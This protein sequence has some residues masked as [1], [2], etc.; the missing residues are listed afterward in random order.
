MTDGYAVDGLT[1]EGQLLSDLMLEVFRLNGRLLAAGDTLVAPVGL[2]SA[3]WQILGAVAMAP[4]PRP[5]AHLARRMGVS[6]QAVQRLVNEMAAAGLVVLQPNPDHRRAKLVTLT[7]AG[8]DALA[9]AIGRHRPWANRLSQ[10]LDAP[11]LS[12]ALA[13]LRNLSQRLDTT[14]RRDLP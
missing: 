10:G 6:R 11:A 12:T 13:L 14:R 5:V 2:T 9:G 7:P 1:D 3:R 4:E 8:R